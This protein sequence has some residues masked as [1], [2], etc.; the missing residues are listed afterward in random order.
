MRTVGQRRALALVPALLLF[1][2]V[3]LRALDP[4]VVAEAR[5]RVF[6]TYQRLEPRPY[7]A[8]AVRV[9]DIDGASLDRYGQWPWPRTRLA[10]LVARLDALGASAIVFNVLFAEPDRTSPRQILPLWTERGGAPPE[11]RSLID[12]LPDHDAAL[13]EAIAQAPVVVGFALTRT[14]PARPPAAPYAVA[15]IGGDPLPFLPE[16]GGAE[17]NLPVIER[18]AA[19]SGSLT[20]LTERDGVDRRLSLV[21]RLDGVVY[22]SLVAEALRVAMRET[23]YLI[24][25]DP[26]VGIR[27]VRIGDRTVPTDTQGRVWLHFTPPVAERSVSAAAVLSGEVDPAVIRGHVVFVGASA[28]GLAVPRASPLGPTTASVE[29]H[30]QLAEQIL[31]DHYLTRPRW[32]GAVEIFALLAAG[33]LAILLVP[34]LGAFGGALVA[35]A[36]AGALILLAWHSYAQWRWLLDPAY[37]AAGVILVSIAA[38]LARMLEVEEERRRIRLAFGQYMAPALVERLAARP[39]LLRLG[40]ETREMTLLF[41]DIRGFTTIAERLDPQSLTRLLNDYLTPMTAAILGHGGTVERYVGDAIA[42]FWNAPL[43]DPEHARHACE[44]AL[45]MRRELAALNDRL[46]AVAAA[47]GRVH[48]PIRFGI[49]LNTGSCVVGNFGSQQRF[50][51]SAQ[52]DAANLAARLEGLTK[53]YGVDIIAGEGTLAAAPCFA[54]LELDVVRVRN[55]TRPVRIFALLG[56]AGLR[57]APAFRELRAAHDGMLAAVRAGERERAAERLAACRVLDDGRLARVY[58]LYERRLLAEGEAPPSAATERGT[59]G[60]AADAGEEHGRRLRSS[61]A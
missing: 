44:A 35:G 38:S 54:A 12:A 20:I 53:V 5:L 43:D 21:F 29:L 46:A 1:A 2:A 39:E 17:T 16:F 6:D 49:G 61:L 24:D 27:G 33:G 28:P 8:V 34:R 37:P 13:G 52:G 55:R 48:A 10:E 9:V 4:A 25:V 58:D 36:G 3:V 23:L 14:R 11:L 32:A 40:G 47:E 60:A 26:A 19:G 45:A 22:P 30:A 42:A 51:Y 7:R 50:G 57:A 56:D 18:A 41:C 59:A 15:Q 31:L